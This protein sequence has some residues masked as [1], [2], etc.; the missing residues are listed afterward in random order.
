MN[1]SSMTK[2]TLPSPFLH[3]LH[4]LAGMVRVF[5]KYFHFVIEDVSFRPTIGCRRCYF[6]VCIHSGPVIHS[7]V[8]GL[9]S[10]LIIMVY[11]CCR[12]KLRLETN[13]IY[14]YKLLKYKKKTIS[15]AINLLD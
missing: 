12:V 2:N 6:I 8:A 14:I 13:V 10:I 7:G 4:F 5:I 11:A 15:S 9:A 3:F 1:G